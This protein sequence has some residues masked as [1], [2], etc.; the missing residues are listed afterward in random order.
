M[1]P[2]N[3]QSRWKVRYSYLAEQFRDPTEILEELRRFLPTGDFTLGRPVGEFEA[4]FAEVIGTKHAIGVGSGTDAIKIP[5][6]ALGLQPGDEVITA[7][8]TFIATVGAINEV[9]A[10][11]VFIDCDDTFCMDLDQLEA[12][13]TERT[14]AIVPVHLTGYMTDMPRLMEIANR[15]G[16]PVVEDACQGI[17][18]ATEGRCAGSWGNAGAFSLHPLKN[19]N[20][21]ADGGVIVTND[22]AMADKLRLL[23]NHGLRNRDEVEILGYNSRL[24][25]VQAIV[26]K[27]LIKDVHAITA[28]RIANAERYD[29]AFSR[30]PGLRIP[31][32]PAGNRRVYHLYIVFSDNRDALMRH[33]LEAGVEVKVHYPIPLYQQRGLQQF[34]Y[35]AGD[36]PV[37][38][39]HARE[40]ITFP[41]D[42]HLTDDQIDYVI[43][44]VESFHVRR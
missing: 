12:A 21:W 18:A 44:V 4:L 24:D 17:L 32:R 3:A 23:R 11:P 20:V 30:I 7:A 9:G 2:E 5:L 33:C 19:L 34:G 14:K 1:M 41:A 27:W 15:R 37:T 8:N 38:D 39:R 25:S 35:R 31:P 22:D 13:I 43:D 40:I 16:L 36:F 28:K 6:K 10:R 26:G 42:Q 29:A